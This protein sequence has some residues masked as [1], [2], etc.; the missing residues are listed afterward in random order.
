MGTFPFPPFDTWSLNIN[1][2]GELQVSDLQIFV[3]KLKGIENCKS[4]GERWVRDKRT[5]ECQQDGNQQ[6]NEDC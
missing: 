3:T 1:I 6:D 4:R 2:S 5:S